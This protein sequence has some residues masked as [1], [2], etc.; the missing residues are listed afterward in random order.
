MGEVATNL[1]SPDNITFNAGSIYTDVLEK[2]KERSRNHS[3]KSMSPKEFARQI[4][5]RIVLKSPELGK[6]EYVW[7]GT[8][9]GIVWLLD[10]IEWRKIFDGLV[11]KMVGLDDRK[12]QEAILQKGRALVNRGKGVH[13]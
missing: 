8:N 10:I 12:I 3:K 13:G 9:A 4:A 6:G 1:M 11:K 2:T 5:S 7:K